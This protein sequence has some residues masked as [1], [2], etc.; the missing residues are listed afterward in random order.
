V[1]CYLGYG[2]PFG[3][4]DAIDRFGP[5]TRTAVK[6]FQRSAGLEDDGRV[7]AGTT[8]ALSA[9]CQAKGVS[10]YAASQIPCSTQSGGGNG[11]TKLPP[12]DP[13]K[14]PGGADDPVYGKPPM[15]PEEGDTCAHG[16]YSQDPQ[17]L[18]PEIEAS[19]DAMTMFGESGYFFYIPRSVQGKIFQLTGSRIAGMASGAE[20]P[21]PPSMV[22]REALTQIDSEL[23]DF[24]SCRWDGPISNMGEQASLVWDGAL[25]LMAMAMKTRGIEGPESSGLLGSD[26]RLVVP[27]T[28]LGM[29]DPGFDGISQADKDKLVGVRVGFIATDKSM[30]NA[31]YVIGKI[32]KATGPS[33]E[34]NMFEVEVVSTFDGK[35][36]SPELTKHHGFKVGSNAYFSMKTP[37]GIYRRYKS[38][39]V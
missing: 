16:M 13:N 26:E 5:K 11:G 12:A 14:K 8:A 9:A 30:Q 28:A 23:D 18:S 15:G 7:G 34:K 31:E 20:S 19:D 24:I 17:Y 2:A 38:G 36:V 22:L 21:I 25:R 1:L 27:R 29:P 6:N 37:T 35:N 32:R 3:N 4:S 33:G 10:I 39:M